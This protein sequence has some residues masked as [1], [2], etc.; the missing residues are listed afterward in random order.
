MRVKP[1][2]FTRTPAIFQRSCRHVHI[3][4]ISLR[5][6]STPHTANMPPRKVSAAVAKATDFIDF[7]NDSPTRQ[8]RSS[9]W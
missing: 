8:Y 9:S 6:Y 3:S 2:M 5:F 4:A 7:V 1:S